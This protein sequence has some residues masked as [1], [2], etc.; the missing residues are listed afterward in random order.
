M[1]MTPG[2]RRFTLTA[3]VASSVGWFGAVAVFLGLAVAGFTSDD[4]Q[5]VRASYL[6]MGTT[7]RFVIVPLC[8]ASVL[9]GFV[10]SLGTTLGLF[11]H[12]WI[13]I[14]LVIT[15]PATIVLFVHMRP[16]S[17]VSQVA[18]E[19]TLSSGDLGLQIQMLAA[20]GAALLALLVATVVST[21]KPRGL[22]QYGWRKQQ[23]RLQSQP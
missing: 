11:L 1:T 12:Y 10:S 8:L 2:V 9:T 22:T 13:V 18:S 15:I 21:Y 16:I 19:R 3:H 6:V 14:K 17:L 5:M 7:T 4:S 23:E 20:A